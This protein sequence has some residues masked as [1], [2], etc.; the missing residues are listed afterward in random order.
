[1]IDSVNH[2]S[3][4]EL[5]KKIYDIL[6][7]ICFDSR[8]YYSRSDSFWISLSVS[9][10]D[11]KIKLYN[12]KLNYKN[13]IISGFICQVALDLNSKEVVLL[14]NSNKHIKFTS[15]V[16]LE[17]IIILKVLDYLEKFMLTYG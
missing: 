2:Y 8:G 4:S 1:M 3:Y 5:D 17:K 6:F 15:L 10:S 12:L 16:R 9:N 11:S 13:F 14:F 7:N